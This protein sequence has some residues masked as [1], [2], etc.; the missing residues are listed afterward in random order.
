MVATRLRPLRTSSTAAGMRPN[1]WS[2]GGALVRTESRRSRLDVCGSGDAAAKWPRSTFTTSTKS[3]GDWIAIAWKEQLADRADE[4][5]I[6]RMRR[7]LRASA[8][9]LHSPRSH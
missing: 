6:H 1:V 3:H 7:Q 8:H 4:F 5:R 9:S 2:H